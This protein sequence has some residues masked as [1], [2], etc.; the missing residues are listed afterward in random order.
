MK[1]HNVAAV[2]G[3]KVFL[4]AIIFLALGQAS[5]FAHTDLTTSYPASGEI[6]ASM[7]AAISVEFTENLML[8]G[9]KTVN[10]ISLTA[11]DGTEIAISSMSVIQNKI[12]ADV[13]SGDFVN[14]KYIVAYK[15]VAADGHKISG[16]YAFTLSDPNLGMAIPTST[17]D[18]EGEEDEEH[19]LGELPAG[20]L[21]AVGALVMVLVLAIAYRRFSQK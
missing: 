5:T 9:D 18:D 14:G 6:V 13:A 7:P 1:S 12:T 8:L 11:P 15:V 20:V 3:L 19:E 16:E 21:V 4:L 17:G 2:N 10:T